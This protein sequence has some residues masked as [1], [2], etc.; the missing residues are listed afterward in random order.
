MRSPA[1]SAGL[2]IP[3]VL[4]CLVSAGPASARGA[5]RW[6]VQAVPHGIASLGPIACPSTST[7]YAT[8]RTTSDRP[9][10]IATTNGGTG[11]ATQLLPKAAASVR[12]AVIAC[13]S[14]HECMVAHAFSARNRCAS[15]AAVR[16]PIAR[17]ATGRRAR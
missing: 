13:P 7:C 9:A 11:W 2:A 3:A 5:A 12:E 14:R 10:M 8:A 6:S 1:V 15:S 4:L 17:P 16:G